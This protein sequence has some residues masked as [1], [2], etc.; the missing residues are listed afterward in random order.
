MTPAGTML[1]PSGIAISTAAGYQESPAAAFDGTSFLVV[2]QD[3]RS[4][5]YSD[6]YG[7]RVRPDGTVHDEGPVVS[8]EG[9]QWCPALAR[10]TGNRMFLVYEGW[11]GTV[12]GKTYNTDR[13]WGKVNPVPGVE[14]RENSEV[15]R[16]KGGAAIVRGVLHLPVS[17]F[18]IHTSLFDMTGRA[19]T[20]LHPGPNDVRSLAPGTYFVRAVSRKLSAVS[21][22]KVIIAR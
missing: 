10:G 14:E 9:D 3:W 19:V 5:Y 8:Q 13:I 22:Q 15:R 20:V 6:I 1:D 7:A 17:P 16:V 4:I 12:S 21:C 18:T 11:A 2:W